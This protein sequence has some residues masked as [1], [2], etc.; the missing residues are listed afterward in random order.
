MFRLY[1]LNGSSSICYVTQ[2]TSLAMD[3]FLV[4]ATG[5]WTRQHSPTELTNLWFLTRTRL[6]TL[7]PPLKYF[8]KCQALN[9]VDGYWSTPN[10]LQY[11]YTPGLTKI[12][13]LCLHCR[14]W[15]LVCSFLVGFN[16]HRVPAY[17]Y[18]IYL[19]GNF[20]LG[21][22]LA[23]LFFRHGILLNSRDGHKHWFSGIGCYIIRFNG[24]RNSKRVESNMNLLSVIDTFHRIYNVN[25]GMGFWSTP[26]WLAFDKYNRTVIL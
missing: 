18:Y 16:P 21:K 23:M 12:P 22:I 1:I 3:P 19:S 15:R 7:R 2:E 6:Q 14:L 13:C 25:K 5:S 17:S 4:P 9:Q 11:I 10:L 24:I 26:D 8:I 20:M